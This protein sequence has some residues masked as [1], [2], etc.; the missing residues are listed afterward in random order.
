[1][2][3]VIGTLAYNFSVILPLF[4]GEVFHRGGGTYGALLLAMGV[5]ALAGALAIASRR[6]PSYRLLVGVT[7]A[8]GVLILA[9]A[10]GADACRCL[11]LLVPM[12]AASIMFIATGQLA[13]AAALER[14]HAR[15]R[16]GALGHRLPGLDAHRR[17][18]DRLLAAHFGVRVALGIGGVAALLVASG[19]ASP[20][21]ASATPGARRSQADGRLRRRSDRQGRPRGGRPKRVLDGALGPRP[22]PVWRRDETSP[23][24]ALAGSRASDGTSARVPSRRGSPWPTAPERLRDATP[25]ARVVRPARRRRAAGARPGGRDR[26]RHRRRG[27]RPAPRRARPRRHGRPRARQRRLRHELA[28]RRPRD[29]HARQPRADRAGELQPRLLRGPRPRA[30]AST[31]ATTRAARCR[32]PRRPSA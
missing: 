15:P 2:M 25:S 10:L 24:A 5:G 23:L 26:R 31:S 4:A 1:M 28:R 8:F 6:R 17:A 27:G 32:S 7:L 14:R 19:P 22:R 29:P 13:A 11:V 18:A 20:C 12:G 16:D 3:A 9:V 30:P 21:A